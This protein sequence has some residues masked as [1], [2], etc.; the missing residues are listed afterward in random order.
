[1]VSRREPIELLD[2]L[3]L[4]VPPR[5]SISFPMN[6]ERA[7]CALVLLVGDVVP[8]VAPVEEDVLPELVPESFDVLPV[9]VPTRF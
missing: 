6:D 1:M 9:R 8:E 7:D 2:E 3:V 4:E 5:L